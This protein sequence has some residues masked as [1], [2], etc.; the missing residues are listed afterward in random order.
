MI[1]V[2]INIALWFE[3][4]FEE[5]QE[6]QI[7]QQYLEGLVEDLK[8]DLR[9]LEDVLT[10]NQTKVE[11]LQ[12]ALPNL[13]DLPNQPAAVQTATFFE[14]SGYQ[15]FEPSDFTY[16][17]MQESGD[18]RL[19]S[20]SEVKQSLLRLVRFYRHVDVLQANFIQAM[21]DGYIPLM[22]GGFD[23]V[24]QRIS[25]PALVEQL[26]FRNFYAYSLQDTAG[27]LA[28]YESAQK[29]AQKLLEQIQAQLA[30]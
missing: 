23:L 24:Q 8:V 3:G 7:E 12:A 25:D 11:R 29:L 15:F 19:L 5:L 30:E 4:W 21:D 20:N 18:F 16:R 17:S 22:M 2:G 1:I 28:A 27:R 10:F 13:A 6:A 14:P 9:N 26:S